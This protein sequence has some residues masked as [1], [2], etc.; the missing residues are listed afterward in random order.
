M[1]LDKITKLVKTIAKMAEDNEKIMLPA[2]SVKLQKLAEAHPYD[3]TIVAMTNII[4]RMYEK[5]YMITRSELKS[6]YNKLYTSNTKFASYFEEELGNGTELATPVF[7][8]KES[9][10][11]ENVTAKVVD[12]ILANALN[13]AF[14]KDCALKTYS[15]A[16]ANSAKVVVAS[17]LDNWNLKASNVEVG[18]G[19]QHFIIVTASYNTPKG[20]TNILIPVETVKG[21]ALTP[22]VFMCNAGPQEL[23]HVNIKEYITTFAGSK[24][25]VRAENVLEILTRKVTGGAVANSVEMAAIKI[26]SGKQHAGDFSGIVGLNVSATPKNVEVE[27]ARLPEADTFEAKFSTASGIAG[28]K[29]GNDK[30]NLGRD[31]I[32]RTLAGFGIKN[33]QMN[34]VSCNENTIYFGVSIFGGKTS[35]KVP[36]KVAGNR[37]SYPDVLICNGSVAAFT[38]ETISDLLVS[39][40]TDGKIAAATS[41]QHGLSVADLIANVKSA[42]NE[43]NYAKAEDALNVLQN[44]GNESAYKEAFAAYMAGMS[45]VK[46]TAGATSTCSLIVKN[47]HSTHALCGHT[48]LPLHKVYQDQHGNCHPNYRKGMDE[49]SEAAFFMTSKIL[50]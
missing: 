46:K 10:P 40:N 37:I 28:F 34:V 1:S 8:P 36:V 11:I 38:K 13:A 39:G 16:N 23:N 25:K 44:T 17:N 29:F 21:K 32:A 24:L 20:V 3:Q 33:P 5:K 43:E 35:F 41:A 50:G 14:D 7:A 30:L 12:P 45:G 42:V 27:V 15:D 26:A 48:N 4:D 31:V 18:A 19:N 2:L 49:V 47:A 9:A 22:S 6:L